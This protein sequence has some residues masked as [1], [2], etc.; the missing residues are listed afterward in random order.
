MQA[1]SRFRLKPDDLLNLYVRS[2]DMQMVP[3]GAVAHL[4]SEVAP[5]LITLYNLYASSTI[6]GAPASGVARTSAL[7]SEFH[8]RVR[9]CANMPPQN[10][11]SAQIALGRA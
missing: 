3:I 5:S 4:G 9:T 2:Q 8:M 11:S 6:I 1:D 7:A 10:N